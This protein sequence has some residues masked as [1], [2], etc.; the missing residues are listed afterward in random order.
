MAEEKKMNKVYLD[1]SENVLRNIGKN[2]SY[3]AFIEK[4]K[5]KKLRP[6]G[7]SDN[8]F[9]EVINF[10]WLDELEMVTEKIMSIASK[11]RTHIK[12][13]KDVKKAEQAVKIDN[14]DIIETLKVPAYWKQKG[15]RFLPEK[16]YTDIFEIEYAIYENRFIINLVDK[17]ML[18]LSQIISQLY[19]KIKHINSRFISSYI[20]YSDLETIQNF[21]DFGY[22]EGKKVN[23]EKDPDATLLTTT[24]SPYVEAL[25]RI[26][27]VRNSVGH[28]R[29]TPFYRDVKKAKPLSDTDVHLTNMLAGDASYAPCYNFY[30]KLLPMLSHGLEAEAEE[31]EPKSYHNFVIGNLLNAFQDIGFKDATINPNGI[32]YNKDDLMILDKYRLRR[33]EM[34][35]YVTSK[36]EDH[37]DL[38]F[39]IANDGNTYKG[40]EN[41]DKK[42]VAVISLDIVP[43][44]TKSYPSVEELSEYFAQKTRSRIQ[45]GG[46]SNAFIVTTVDGTQKEDVIICS[47]EHYK[48]DANLRSM[49]NSCIIFAEGDNFIYSHVCPVCGF[50]VDGEQDDGNCYCANCDSAYTLLRSGSNKTLKESVWIKR[51]R[52][53]EK[54]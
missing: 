48:I 36:D 2:F 13:E 6:T 21:S 20:P 54:I 18:F 23:F 44:F 49:I 25:K 51:L 11:P 8:Y 14:Y 32:K 12:V 37:I 39:E 46:Y 35:V 3:S 42:R 10:P 1:Y 28:V 38:K 52:N 4:S 33:G 16:V 19:A 50:Y 29:S 17:M 41:F 7:L 9:K 53:P 5:T 26:L 45:R 30:L 24:S 22:Q 31:I 15:D 43:T 47:H 40:T 34:S 27:E